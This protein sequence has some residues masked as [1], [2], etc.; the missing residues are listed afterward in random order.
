MRGIMN[1]PKMELYCCTSTLLDDISDNRFTKKNVAKTYALALRSSYPTD[2][3]KVNKA[4]IK[5]WSRNGLE[6]IKRMAWSGKCF[7]DERYYK[8]G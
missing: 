3:G 8:E 1:K 7:E 6:D 5:R 4:I 2:W